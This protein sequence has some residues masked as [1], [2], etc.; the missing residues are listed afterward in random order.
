MEQRQ[1]PD[2]C[3]SSLPPTNI[4]FVGGCLADQ[5]LFKLAMPVGGRVP[6]QQGTRLLGQ[7]EVPELNSALELS[8]SCRFRASDLGVCSVA[9]PRDGAEFVGRWLAGFEQ[10]S[11]RIQAETLEHGVWAH[12]LGIWGA[13][14]PFPRSPQGPE[15]KHPQGQKLGR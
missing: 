13:L 1:P 8:Q 7:W 9:F 11:Q 5:F 4:A 6:T 2:M 14:P 15:S 12:V 3:E 10:T